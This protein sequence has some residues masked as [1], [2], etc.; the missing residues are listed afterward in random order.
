MAKKTDNLD[1]KITDLQNQ[2]GLLDPKPRISIGY[3]PNKRRR[4]IRRQTYTRWYWLRDNP[5]RIEA[6]A[7]WELGDKE[8]AMVIPELEDGDWHSNLQLPDA[9]A[10]IQSQAQE[11]IERKSRPHLLQTEESD[12]PLAEFG[13][14]ILTY[15]MNNT[16]FDY[17]YYLAKLS[18]S[19]RGMSFLMDYWRTEKRTVKLPDSLNPDGTIK[20]I[21]KEITDFDDDYTEWVPNEYIHIDEKAKHIDEAVDGFKREI[22]N[23]EEFHRIFG[24][25]PDFFDTEYVTAGGD[26]SDKSFFKM[27]SDVTAQEVEVLHYFNR[28]IDAYW[29]VANNI[30]IHDGPLPTKHKELPFI[31]VY[32]YRRPGSFYGIGIPKVIHY[33]SEERKSIRNL[34]MDRQKMHL[35]KMFL[36]N[37]AFDLDDED[38][39]TRPHGLISVDTNGQD[40]R[41]SIVPL[42]YGDVPASYFRTEEIL[43]EDIRR[44]HGIDDRIQGV[45][46]GGTA[47]EAAI[48]KESSMKRINL[49]SLT[50]EMDSIIRIGRLKWSNIQ[51]Y[52]GVPRMESITEDNET[53]QKKVYKTISVQGKKFEITKQDGKTALK[54][55]DI[56]GASALAIKP[57]FNKYLEGSYDISVDSDVFA[58]VSKAIE[59]TKKTELYSVMLA[60]PAVAAIMDLAG[61][62]SDVLKVNNI[63]PST[64]LKTTSK[65]SSDWMMQ[66][67]AENMVM[68]SGQ[69]LSGTPDAP[70]EHTLIHLMFTK[71]KEFEALDPTIQGLFMQ[72]IME[73]HD[74]NPNTTSAASMMGGGGQP[75]AGGPPGMLPGPD[76]VP[77]PPPGLQ[78]NT[79]QPQ[80]QV[81]DL[82]P[83]NFGNK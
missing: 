62:T 57:E 80:A 72:H 58:P 19:I 53:K 40:I 8:Y 69:P 1:T 4:Q 66:A 60:N 42:E 52:Y 27:P 59:Q 56:Q 7:E 2:E 68:G 11:T 23:V 13:N 79:S 29:I 71:T 22:Y 83:T 3:N 21:T 74:S 17:Q 33:L 81:A 77:M 61:A 50:N 24:G 65:S 67:E 75:G 25:K 10:A 47:T 37:N 30:T 76:G 46:A 35:N 31:P 41:S 18:A 82:Q 6:E 70:E 12:E 48:L 15:N 39:T 55:S 54:A 43:L 49:I 5:L 32:Q 26:V 34:N 9:F 20:Y 45:Q 36:H 28:A 64:W 16:G 51:F 63:K 14:S 44:A 78:A 73:E 38:L